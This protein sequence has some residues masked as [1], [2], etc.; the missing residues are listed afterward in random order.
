MENNVVVKTEQKVE[1]IDTITKGVLELD[2]DMLSD[3]L[4]LIQFHQRVNELF[5]TENDYEEYLKEVDKACS[6]V[7]KIKKEN[8]TDEDRIKLKKSV[9][10]AIE[11]YGS[12]KGKPII[13]EVALKLR[14]H[15][16]VKDVSKWLFDVTSLYSNSYDMYDWMY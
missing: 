7:L 4:A 3:F 13:M 10:K 14:N 12:L 15:Y 8:V 2:D 6:L 9:G 1:V 5:F 16:L 11:K